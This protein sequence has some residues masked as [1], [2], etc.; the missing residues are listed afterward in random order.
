MLKEQLPKIDNIGGQSLI[1][2]VI[3]VAIGAILVGGA[4]ATIALTLRSNVQNKNIQIA[5][6]LA[7]ETVDQATVFGEARW[8]NIHDLTKS[9]DQWRIATTSQGTF[10]T[11]TGSQEIELDNITFTRYFTV[12]N[13]MRDSSGAIVTS[14]GTDDP[15]TQ[16]ISIFV[17]WL[18]AGQTSEVKL[19]KYLTRSRNLIYRQIDWSGGNNQ[20]G[21]IT[22]VNNRFASS[23]EIDYSTMP[24]SVFVEDFVP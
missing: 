13:V 24:G 21:P 12:E 1:E 20:Q 15:S 14:G 18:E 23:T 4:A 11:S 17:T 22:T 19:E 5:T 9:P 10:S 3:G 6:G 8:R 16:K 2:L 7:Q